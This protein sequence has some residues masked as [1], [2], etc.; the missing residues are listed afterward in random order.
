MA[1]LCRVGARTVIVDYPSAASA[2][3]FQSAGRRL[4]GS[5]GV[6]NEP[7][8]VFTARTISR[9]LESQ[10]FAVRAVHRQFVLPIQ[11]HKA[12]GS[13]GFTLSSERLL[14]RAGLL[15]LFGSPVTVCAD[16]CVSS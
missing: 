6:V 8:R 1:E 9:A 11:L 15:R 7:Y 14:E 12:I 13:R 3:F 16:R 2:A 4:L 5:A 10:G